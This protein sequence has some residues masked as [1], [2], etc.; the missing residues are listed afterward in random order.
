M[1]KD[2]QPRQA[3]DWIKIQYWE[4]NVLGH[5]HRSKRS[6]SACIMIRKGETGELKKLRRNLSML[7]DL[8]KG[9]S[10]VEI[11]KKHFCS[12]SNVTIAV[13]S[14][15]NKA[16]KI[17]GVNGEC[18]YP[19]RSWKRADFTNPELQQELNFFVAMLEEMEVK[20]IKLVD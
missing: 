2:L 15:I 11:S 5:R 14:S 18:P 7:K 12:D 19:Q 3:E 6:A 16:W 10:L 9:E 17:F 4:C 8:Q 20:L 13:N 1:P